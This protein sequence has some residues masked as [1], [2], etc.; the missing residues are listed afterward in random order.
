V[1]AL[2]LLAIL[3][4]FICS[5]YAQTADSNVVNASDEVDI[6]SN[7]AEQPPADGAGMN[8]VDVLH[9]V[10]GTEVVGKLMAFDG[11]EFTV[12]V[13][14][15]AGQIPRAEVVYIALGQPQSRSKLLYVG[16]DTDDLANAAVAEALKRT[17]FDLT[18]ATRLPASLEG[19]DVV[20]LESVSASS[21]DAAKMLRSFVGKGG[22]AVLVGAVPKAL[23]PEGSRNSYYDQD[24]IVYPWDTS[25]IADWVGGATMEDSKKPLSNPRAA[26]SLANPFFACPDIKVGEELYVFQGERNADFFVTGSLSAQARPVAK[27][28]F[29]NEGIEFTHIA[30]FAHPFGQGR[31]YYQF[32]SYEPNHPKLVE[33]LVAG[34]KWAAGVLPEIGG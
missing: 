4:I 13:Q 34:T 11:T 6:L 24:R 25:D 27:I 14:S 32:M 19:F 15:E 31:T 12:D 3:A 21:P 7:T 9:R 1:K 30:A 20:V 22:G 33:L 16:S 28:R 18:S 17:G 10:D 2:S 26:S 5:S 23:C 8:A 29:E